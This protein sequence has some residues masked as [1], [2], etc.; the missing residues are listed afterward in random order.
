M[1]ERPRPLRVVVLSCGDLGIDVARRL[2]Q[3]PGVRDVAL[4]TTPYR[5]TLRS[6]LGRIRHL[7]RMEGWRGLTAALLRRATRPLRRIVA[8]AAREAAAVIDP[9]IAQYHYQDFH[10][11]RC[12]AQLR[13]LEPDLGVVAGTYILREDV[14]SIP[15]LG[16][17]NLHS[18][19]VP[20]YRGSAPAFW[21]LYN[22]ESEVGIT[23]HWVAR[24]VD[25]GRVLLQGSFPLDPAPAGD[26]LRYLERYRREV[27]RPNGIRL[28][29]EAVARIAAG[30]TDGWVQDPTRA[31]TY[32]MPHHHAVRE[33]RRRI[34][35]RR[36]ARLT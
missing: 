24:A 21:E 32:K 5:T 10:E 22:G 7:H 11:P 25:A 2:L 6:L 17:I 1:A 23:I 14:F 34:R 16:S 18:G 30:A 31:R 26:P 3:T 33:L 13:A 29:C 19:K 15:R 9:A 12:L 27:L 8:P 28:L 20:E 36:K 4:V 35:A